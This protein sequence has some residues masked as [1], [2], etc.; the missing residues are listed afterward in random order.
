MPGANGN[1]GAILGCV[2]IAV[3]SEG[4]HGF[5]GHGLRDLEPA[6]IERAF[7]YRRDAGGGIGED[8]LCLSGHSR[9]FTTKGT[10]GRGEKQSLCSTFV[11]LRALRGSSFLPFSSLPSFCSSL[12]FPV[13]LSQRRTHW[14]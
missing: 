10:K 5:C 13:L 3:G 12:F 1:R 9:A 11:P 14:S 4:S 8:L 2:R 6:A 7:R